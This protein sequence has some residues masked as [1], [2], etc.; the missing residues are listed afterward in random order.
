M[1]PPRLTRLLRG[2]A[3]FSGAI[4]LSLVFRIKAEITGSRPDTGPAAWLYDLTSVLVRPLERFDRPR[5]ITEGAFIDL[6][7]L[8]ALEIA[9]CLTAGF[10]AAVLL[11]GKL[12]D[13]SMISWPVWTL[14][15]IRRAQ[16]W[17]L[18]SLAAA[19]WRGLQFVSYAWALLVLKAREQDWDGYKVKSRQTWLYLARAGRRIVRGAGCLGAIYLQ[20]GRLK[21][22]SYL[23]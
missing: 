13:I 4:T 6:P 9:L 12:P 7:S 11:A 3:V 21:V 2:L 15:G 14:A 16:G 20:K 17:T 8:Y 18:R 10:V 22:N 23:D 5:T 1:H 19:Y